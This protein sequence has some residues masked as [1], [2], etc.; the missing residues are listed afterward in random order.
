MKSVS[1]NGDAKEWDEE[2]V[3][4]L[5][6]E[7]NTLGACGGAQGRQTEKKRAFGMIIRSTSSYEEVMADRF[8]HRD[9]ESSR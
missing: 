4:K 1:Y 6:H 3:E 7:S 5:R 8:P 9:L 2:A